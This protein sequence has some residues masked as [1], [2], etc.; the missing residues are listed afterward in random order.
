MSPMGN[1]NLV[2]LVVTVVELMVPVP[3]VNPDTPWLTMFVTSV[4]FPCVPTVMVEVLDLVKLVSPLM[5]STPIP[6]TL[7]VSSVILTV[8]HVPLMIERPVL[9]VCPDTSW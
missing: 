6:Q 9:N 2:E 5:L 7:L 8:C 4:V 3:L 1:V